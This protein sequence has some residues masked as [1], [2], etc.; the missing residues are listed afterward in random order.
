MILV[1]VVGSLQQC[2]AAGGGFK[3]EEGSTTMDE[4]AEVGGERVVEAMDHQI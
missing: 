1:I 3:G 2:S 4:G